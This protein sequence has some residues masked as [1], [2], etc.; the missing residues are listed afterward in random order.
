M[1]SR[2]RRASP[3]S[4]STSR[5][6]SPP[7]ASAA[8]RRSTSRPSPGSRA[9]RS[10]TRGWRSPRSP[11]PTARPLP[12]TVGAVDPILGA[13]LTVEIGDAKKIVIRY[14]SA[15]DAG[16]LQWLTPEQT[17]GK[18]QPLSAQPGPGD[19]ESQ[20]DPDP[21]FARRPPDLGS[22]D[23]RPRRADRGDVG[24]QGRRAGDRR[25]RP[26]LHATRWTS[27]SRLT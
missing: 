15:P 26:R 21:G 12:Y 3:M 1:P 18:K 14:T 23:P 8:P 7:S 11:P 16:A 20:L 13:P 10:T 19:R 5:S 2:S 27:P 17:A 9:S 25:R 24:A 6:I 4:R 22:E